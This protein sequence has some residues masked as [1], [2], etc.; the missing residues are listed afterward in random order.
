MSTVSTMCYAQLK[1]K[2]GEPTKFSHPCQ[3]LLA[4]W[5]SLLKTDRRMIAV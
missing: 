2:P 1:S 5:D 4:T 3:P